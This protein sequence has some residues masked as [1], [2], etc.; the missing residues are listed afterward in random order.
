MTI[1]AASRNERNT[2]AETL[3]PRWTKGLPHGGEVVMNDNGS[4]IEKMTL[5]QELYNEEKFTEKW[6]R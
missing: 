1:L 6:K 3:M 5:S 2:I 4:K